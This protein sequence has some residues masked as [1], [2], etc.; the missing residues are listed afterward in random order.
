[1]ACK[2]VVF[3]MAGTTVQDGE[4]VVNRALRTALAGYGVTVTFD[5]VNEVMGLP[6]PDAIRKLVR[7]HGDI[8]VAKVYV[9]FE[10]AM[11]D[12]YR[13][14]PDVTAISGAEEV[15]AAL[16]SAGI[17]V[18]LDTG[19]ARPIVDAIVERLGWAELLDA[20]V[21]SDEV[22]HG[23]PQK[24]LVLEAM[25]RTGITDVQTVAKVGDTPSDIQEGQAAGCMWVIAV[26]E[27]SHT[28]DQLAPYLPTHIVPN[29]THVPALVTD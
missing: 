2:L 12:H 21:A 9:D 25:A 16:R 24:D 11:V 26:T 18:A 1:M 28:L 20:T 23:R 13:T 3:D 19:F 22:A 15:F 8:S 7:G 5:D 29:I 6:K 17:K 27:G 4:G 10:N 14:S